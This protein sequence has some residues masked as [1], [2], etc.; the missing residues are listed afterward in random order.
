MC[1]NF[2]LSKS[3]FIQTEVILKLNINLLEFCVC[4]QGKGR[5]VVRLGT[6]RDVSQA[7]CDSVHHVA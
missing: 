7:A 2:A 5:A 6:Y 1:I 3:F 4:K